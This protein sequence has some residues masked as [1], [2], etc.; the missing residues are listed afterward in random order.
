MMAYGEYFKSPTQVLKDLKELRELYNKRVQYVRA[1]FLEAGLRPACETNA[2]FFTL[3]KTPDVVLGT[4]VDKNS[5]LFNRKVI[6]ETG[7]IGV[8]FPGGLMR[9]AVCTDVLDPKFQSRFESE[10][11]RLNPKYYS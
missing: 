11:N 2:G 1:K 3:W 6:S 9:Y 5:E 4:S 10:L 7:I 8:H